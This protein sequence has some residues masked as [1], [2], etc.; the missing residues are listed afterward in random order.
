M[1]VKKNK[2]KV[3]GE[4]RAFISALLKRIAI[5]NRRDM[6]NAERNNALGEDNPRFI[7]KQST[8][9]AMER[10]EDRCRALLSKRTDDDE[11]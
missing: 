11:E 7:D 1:A 10:V 2:F 8:Q 4:F 3:K 9:N 5:V 6:R